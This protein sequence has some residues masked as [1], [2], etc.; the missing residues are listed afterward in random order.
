M[1]FKFCALNGF[2]VID[3]WHRQLFPKNSINYPIYQAFEKV[4]QFLTENTPLKY[5][6]TNIEFVAVKIN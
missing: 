6:A 5:L 2:E 3:I 1:V 4:D